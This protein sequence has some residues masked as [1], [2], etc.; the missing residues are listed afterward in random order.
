MIAYTLDFPVQGWVLL[1]AVAQCAVQPSP[2]H[3]ALGDFVPWNLSLISVA[4]TSPLEW[5]PESG[6]QRNSQM[7]K[8]R[9]S[10]LFAGP[11]ASQT[12]GHVQGCAPGLVAVI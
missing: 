2:A 3:A 8:K 5:V 12:D 4:W 11:S 9:S 7:G 6:L 1:S 10:C